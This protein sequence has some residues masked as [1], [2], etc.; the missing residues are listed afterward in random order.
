MEK[1][2]RNNSVMSGAN[3]QCAMA[4]ESPLNRK[5]RHIS[6]HYFNQELSSVKDTEALLSEFHLSLE[7]CSQADVQLHPNTSAPESAE[8]CSQNDEKPS[9]SIYLERRKKLPP[10]PSSPC[11]SQ[12]SKSDAFFYH[13][14]TRVAGERVGREW[15]TGQ[16]LFHLH[17]QQRSTRFHVMHPSSPMFSSSDSG[18]AQSPCDRSTFSSPGC[19]PLFACHA[20]EPHHGCMSTSDLI[21]AEGADAAS[22]LRSDAEGAAVDYSQRRRRWLRKPL[23]SIGAVQRRCLSSSSFRAALSDCLP[24]GEIGLLFTDA[25]HA[26]LTESFLDRASST[27]R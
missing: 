25:A 3:T 16:A 4:N 20:L 27:A 1:L 7:E 9:A 12:V 23:P 2:S 8:S 10:K 19:S 11:P 26:V 6:E 15:L 21:A 17:N 5:A 13:E 24:Q 22:S 18:P 14:L